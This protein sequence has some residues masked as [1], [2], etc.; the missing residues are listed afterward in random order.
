MV[1]INHR[2]FLYDFMSKYNIL[3]LIF[4]ILFV[5]CNEE[6]KQDTQNFD[7]VII[8]KASQ[9]EIVSF[10]SDSLDVVSEEYNE[11][12][13]EF[14][15]TY[16]S[17]EDKNSTSIVGISKPYKISQKSVDIIKK[18]EGCRLTAYKYTNKKTGKREKFYTIGYGHV[19]FPG[20]PTPMKI[21]LEHAERLLKEDLNKIYVPSARRLLEQIDPNFKV[22]Q[23]FFDG[24]VS[25]VYNCGEAGIQKSAFWK[26]LKKCRVD[27]S[28]KINKKDYDQML[29]AIKTARASEPG[30]FIR[31]KQEYALMASK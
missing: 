28:G 14:N 3:I 15:N 11:F 18:F 21:T 9:N 26:L 27:Q 8:A 5:S 24:L 1:F 19:I 6:T 20:D 23:G 10:E 7:K 31:R 2:V 17:Q 4:S 25:L 30:H 16:I 22:T 12:L 29:Q 13:R